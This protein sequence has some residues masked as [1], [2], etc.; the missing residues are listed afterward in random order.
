MTFHK[1]LNEYFYHIFY[2]F[3]SEYWSN[4]SLWLVI[5]GASLT[6]NAISR[7]ITCLWGFNGSIFVLSHWRILLHCFTI[8]RLEESMWYNTWCYS[9]EGSWRKKRTNDTTIGIVSDKSYH[10][11]NLYRIRWRQNPSSQL[12]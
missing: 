5:V 7:T 1:I 4:V 11:E 2:Q 9:P 8:N 12:L 10:Q 6:T 3:W